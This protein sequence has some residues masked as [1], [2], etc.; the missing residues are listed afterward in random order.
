[1]MHYARKQ[2]LFEWLYDLV[3]NQML[4]KYTPLNPNYK[5]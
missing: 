5:L 1:M 4:K 3:L 2:G